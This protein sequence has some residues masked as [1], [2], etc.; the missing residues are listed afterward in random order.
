MRHTLL[1]LLTLSALVTTASAD[2]GKTRDRIRARATPLLKKAAAAV[3]AD[4]GCVIAVDLD[5]STMPTKP[6]YDINR[7]IQNVGY[8]TTEL[9]TLSSHVCKT[10]ADKAATCAHVK[11]V[12]AAY[13]DDMG[14]SCSLDDKTL[15]CVTN[16][17]TVKWVQMAQALGMKYDGVKDLDHAFTW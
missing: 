7:I 14:G 17:A 15:T 1:M 6:S 4:C 9:A 3:K 13:T 11:S 5:W 8:V 12:K 2:K 16:Q 10:K